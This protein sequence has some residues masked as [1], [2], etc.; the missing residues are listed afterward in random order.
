LK[1]G[2]EEANSTDPQ[3][4]VAMSA[5]PGKK[6]TGAALAALALEEASVGLTFGV[7]GARSLKLLE[8]IDESRTVQAVRVVNDAAASYTASAVWQSGAGLA[9]ALLTGETGE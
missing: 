8:A 6:Y 4:S 2:E 7:T 9:C 1:V 3:V 5:P